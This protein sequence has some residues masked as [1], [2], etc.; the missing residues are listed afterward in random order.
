M[1]P[2]GKC[3]GKVKGKGKGQ[4][5]KPSG[6]HPQYGKGKE[7]W[8]KQETKYGESNTKKVNEKTYFWCP[9]HQAWNIHF[10]EEYKLKSEQ[11]K[12]SHHSN[13]KIPDNN[14]LTIASSTILSDINSEENE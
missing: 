1:L 2:T 11:G 8:K 4:D 6:K 12:S 7:E 10:L 13:N 14:H 9:I 3:K 5:K